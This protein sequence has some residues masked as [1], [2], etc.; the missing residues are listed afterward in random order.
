MANKQKS[1]EINVTDIVPEEDGYSQGISN[2]KK[3]EMIRKARLKALK[4]KKQ[5]ARLKAILVLLL[6][7]IVG[8]S[9]VA[10]FFIFVLKSPVEKGALELESGNFEEAILE[11]NQGLD[12]LDY[13]AESYK[14]IG[15]ANYEL[16]NYKDAIESFEQAVLKSQ[17]NTSYIYNLIGL[18]YMNLEEYQSALDHFLT[19]IDK[20]GSSNE[21]M[22]QMRLYEIICMERLGDWE[23]AKAKATLY[24]QSYPGDEE[25]KKELQFLETR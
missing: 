19:G 21:L 13:I 6:L 18:S 14:G 5:Q 24:V 25:M 7:M 4:K 16:G 9:G 2:V 12:D 8:A 20:P 10:Y 23:G 15:I 1:K 22:Q 11:F 3:R 17:G